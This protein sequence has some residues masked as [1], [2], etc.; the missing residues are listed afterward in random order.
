VD[1]ARGGLCWLVATLATIMAINIYAQA[2]AIPSGP[3][4]FPTIWSTGYSMPQVGNGY[5]WSFP[6]FSQLNQGA[7][8]EIVSLKD[9][10][11]IHVPFFVSGALRMWIDDVAVLPDRRVIVA[12][13]SSRSAGDS[14]RTRFWATLGPDAKLASFI[15]TET[16]ESERICGDMEGNVWVFGQDKQAESKGTSYD[17]LKKYSPE[18]R[19]I[20]SF[21]SSREVASSG[22]ELSADSDSLRS[23]KGLNVYLRCSRSGVGVYVTLNRSWFFISPTDDTVRVW[24][25]DLPGRPAGLTGFGLSDDGKAYASIRLFSQE[26]KSEV[27]RGLY[28][29]VLQTDGFATWV[30]VPNKNSFRSEPGGFGELVGSDAGAIVFLKNADDVGL[31]DAICCNDQFYNSKPPLYWEKI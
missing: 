29:L 13:L 30:P 17:A 18:G 20:K 15:D 27:R 9:R 25:A 6:R 1:V 24:Q 4:N 22:Y 23:K 12:G 5:L 16:Y 14:S 28:T 11:E 8:I 3:V 31:P 10:S 26:S 7:A 2:S 21:L 19:L